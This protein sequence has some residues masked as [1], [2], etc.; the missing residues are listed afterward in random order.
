[1]ARHL[2]GSLA[3]SDDSSSSSSAMQGKSE[4]GNSKNPNRRSR[5]DWIGSDP[6]AFVSVKKH[7]LGVGIHFRC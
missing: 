2:L 3:L 1:M 5:F 4:C 7:F 6:K